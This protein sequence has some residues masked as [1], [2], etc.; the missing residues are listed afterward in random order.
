MT[1]QPTASDAI[2]RVS[3]LSK[4]FR[5]FHERNQSL[6]QSLLKRRRS[7]HEDFWALQ[8]VTF[9]VQRG[10][11]F[12]V[13]GHNG[14][15]KSTLLKCLTKI[16]VPDEGSVSVDGSISALL[17]LGAGFHP[18]LSGRENVFLNAAILGVPRR[19]IQE[20]F[21]DIVEFSGLDQ[22]IDTPVKNYSSGMFVRLG[23][24]VAINVDPDV[25]I[26]DEVL[27]VGDAEFQAKCGDKIAE[28][29][30]RKKTIVLVTHSIAD[31]I[32]LCETAAWIDHGKLRMIGASQE[33][34]DAYLETAHIGR[35]V[36]QQDG[37]RWGTGE[38]RIAGVELLDG[39]LQPATFV[40]SGNAHA[41]RVHLTS[42]QEVL[43]PEIRISIFDQSATLVTEVSTRTRGVRLDRVDGD[44]S[45][46]FEMDVMPLIEGTYE[47]SC[48]V[49]DD[50]GQR[51]LDVR[52]R[53][54]RFDVLKGD[55]S[56]GGL[57]SLGGSWNLD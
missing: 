21:D 51:E 38:V 22:F 54:L 6:K 2:V 37:L 44:R 47:L 7:T 13:V 12:A 34:T 36:H 41:I 23:F 46:T 28:Y 20:R 53:F 24:A 10:Q 45:L 16:L 15:G 4:R 43:G 40:R 30:D 11:T 31:V 8:N 17:E 1:A 35:S 14:S 27:A 33:V 29:R 42:T 56:D 9:D 18:E 25:L 32:R 57:V 50:S 48:S 5:L 39:A 19:F 3:H 52:S 49:I 26:I 55:A